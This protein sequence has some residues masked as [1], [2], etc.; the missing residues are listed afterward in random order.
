MKTVN[1]IT[2]DIIERSI[3]KLLS[4]SSYDGNL[5]RVEMIETFTSSRLEKLWRMHD[6]A[7]LPD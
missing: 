7:S 1:M 6:L 3:L 5:Q 4:L 2:I